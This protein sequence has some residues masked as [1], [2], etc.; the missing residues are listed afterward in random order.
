MGG[1]ALATSVR[2]V[3][4]QAARW[5]TVAVE[6]RLQQAAPASVTVEDAVA[7]VR[8][9]AQRWTEPSCTALVLEE[10]GEAPNPNAAL[11]AGA[12]SNGVNDVVWISDETWVYGASVL[13]VTAPLTDADGF[14]SES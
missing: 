3:S 7:A 1:D 4:G 9:G 2:V 10:T 11:L 14:I 12:P 5:P 8:L 13:G 6:W